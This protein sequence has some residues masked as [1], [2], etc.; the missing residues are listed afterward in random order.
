MEL[1]IAMAQT[2]AQVT[3]KIAVLQTKAEQLRKREVAG[4]VERIKAAINAYGL[5]AEHLFGSVRAPNRMAVK[6]GKRVA[7]Q[8]YADGLG[9]V[10]GGMGPRPR[11]LRAALA[12]GRQ[13]EEFVDLGSGEAGGAP[14][15]SSTGMKRKSVKRRARR[16]KRRAT[17]QAYTNGTQT[18]SGYGRQPKWLQ[19]GLAGGKT[20]EEMK[21]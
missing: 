9:N 7:K 16:G 14:A 20:L 11:W 13:I 2:Y 6:S 3:Q 21:V 12:E 15:A 19:D 10:W 1:T 17:R 5:T 8:R 18:W 4:V